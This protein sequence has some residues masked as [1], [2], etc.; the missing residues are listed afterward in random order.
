LGNN[1]TS[2][3]IVDNAVVP[4]GGMVYYLY[5]ATFV[6]NAIDTGKYSTLLTSEKPGSGPGDRDAD[7]AADPD[8]C[9]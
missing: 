5:R 4:P 8:A 7:I 6:C 2:A 1:T 3:A 9:P